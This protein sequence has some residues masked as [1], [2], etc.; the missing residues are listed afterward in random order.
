MM[1]RAFGAIC[2]GITRRPLQEILAKSCI[3]AALLPAILGLSC[4]RAEPQKRVETGSA[5]AVVAGEQITAEMVREELGR[6]FRLARG[7]LTTAQKT[8]VL[9]GLI[10]SRALYAKAKATGFDRTPEM[11]ARIR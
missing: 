11:E 8:A 10:Q 6:Q 3:A 5:V 4:R 9:E 1:E 7:E 2:R